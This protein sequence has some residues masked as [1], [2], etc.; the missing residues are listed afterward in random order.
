[1]WVLKSMDTYRQTKLDDE[2]TER[3]AL[4][5]A[6]TMLAYAIGAALFVQELRLYRTIER[7]TDLFVDT[8]SAALMPITLNI[9]F[10]ALPCAVTSLDIENLIG[11]KVDNIAIRKTRLR[12][13]GSEIEPED[14]A[15]QTGQ[16]SKDFPQWEKARMERQVQMERQALR[17]E[18]EEAARREGGGGGGDGGGE[19]RAIDCSSRTTCHACVE[20]RCGWCL[21]R[22]RCV[23]DVPG[24]CF[25]PSDQVG[26]AGVGLCPR[27]R[28]L[29]A[30]GGADTAP[31]PNSSNAPGPSLPPP[32]PSA[33][34][35]ASAGAAGAPHTGA[36]ARS[37]DYKMPPEV[38]T[39]KQQ[40]ARARADMARQEIYHRVAAE[41]ATAAAATARNASNATAA[42]V[43]PNATAAVPTSNLAGAETSPPPLLPPQPKHG[44]PKV[45]GS[46]VKGAHMAAA[47]KTIAEPP[48]P[49][50]VPAAEAGEAQKASSRASSQ[51]Q[52]RDSGGGGGGGGS[53]EGCVGW[54]QTGPCDPPRHREPEFDRDCAFEVPAGASG[55]C[56]C[57]NGTRAAEDM[58][59]QH[60]AFRCA[61]LCADSVAIA[62]SA[63]AGQEVFEARPPPAPP[64]QIMLGEP[65][66]G[67]GEPRGAAD[68][69][70]AKG[71]LEEQRHEGCRIEGRFEV[72]FGVAGNFHFSTHAYAAQFMQTDMLS[73]LFG[74]PF[75]GGGLDLGSLD[76]RH[77]ISLLAFG[78][79]TLDVHAA[80]LDAAAATAQAAAE[81]QQQL[82]MS[83]SP[84]SGP[85]R[86]GVG[87][88]TEYFIV[89]VP[90][91][92]VKL[93]GSM[94]R[95]FQYTAHHHVRPAL[96]TLPAVVF[97]Y[98]LSPMTVRVTERRRPLLHF[99]TSVCAIVGG[100]LATMG[101]VHRAVMM[102]VGADFGRGLPAAAPS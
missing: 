16:P 7:T 93:D 13:D 80:Q 96:N 8:E 6:M 74:M 27:R 78:D 102:L 88:L 76:M 21:Q 55:Y 82:L 54:R 101:L 30:D 2:F 72:Q 1:M 89:A 41:E 46:P 87:K 68:K 97:I 98:D 84:L 91:L 69:G 28:S 25:G 49:V 66:G 31:A 90:L 15:L 53:H 83:F 4:G 77:S 51:P 29:Q 57:A 92:H 22:K 95:A 32:L 10:P 45:W 48:P 44:I 85:R 61:D 23:K 43:P 14:E 52:P 37:T 75:G 63:A 20:A 33:A 50:A 64:M 59:C 67:G 38:G 40:I 47:P 58:G 35:G 94:T 86:G 71:Q 26:V 19:D 73:Q 12:R 65:F 70:L 62:R 36:A 11:Q 81:Q 18:N 9:T 56:E 17:R 60:S 34:L 3:S 42:V 99:V 39:P 24:N 100:V 79:E 5:G